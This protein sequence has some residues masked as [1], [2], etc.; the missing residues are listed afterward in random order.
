MRTSINRIAV[1]TTLLLTVAATAMRLLTLPQVQAEAVGE[2]GI[3][4][5]LLIALAA[6]AA[7]L[8]ALAH[9]SRLPLRPME[10][11]QGVLLGIVTAVAGAVLFLDTVMAMVRLNLTGV[12]PP[13]NA[14]ILN[15]ADRVTLW[16]TLVFGF[17]AGV[18]LMT[19]GIRWGRHSSLTLVERLGALTPV[20]WMWCRLAR[21]E[22]SYASAT[23]AKRSFYDFFMLIFLML[24]LLTLARYA[25][26]VA[27][28][29]AKTMRAYSAVAAMVGISSPLTRLGM[30][31][32]GDVEAFNASQLAG[33][34]DFAIGLLALGMT[35]QLYRES[36]SAAKSDEEEDEDDNAQFNLFSPEDLSPESP[37][38]VADRLI[39]ELLSEEQSAEE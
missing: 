34:V 1:W 5:W 24:F 39:R 4:I 38:P 29:S 27:P 17:L 7:V 37:T 21:Y 28:P 32:L 13:P 25:A 18:W 26:D 19:L 20:L 33:V 31:L 35:V 11:E 14:Q 12:T 10:G 2:A 22:L 8:V 23:N 3:S 9:C 36:P 16:L 30:H 6:G 15:T